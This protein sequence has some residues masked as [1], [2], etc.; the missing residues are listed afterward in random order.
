MASL[1]ELQDNFSRAILECNGELITEDVLPDGLTAEERYWIYRNNSYLTLGLA[2]ARNFPVLCQLVGQRFFDH[3]AEEYV[4]KYPP[5]NALMMSY[6]A[7]MADFLGEFNPVADLPYLADVARLEHLWTLCFNG[8]DCF[9]EENAG[10]FDL[11]QLSKI[12]PERFND[13]ILNFL[14][15]MQLMSSV[16]PIVDIWRANQEGCRG[17][18]INIDCGGCYLLLFRRAQAVEIMALDQANYDFLD[19]IRQGNALGRAAEEIIEKY[20][21]FDLQAALQNIL[22]N[23]LI[24]SISEAETE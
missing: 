10:G 24:E 14:P 9:N 22:H 19:R 4:K 3:M 13:L 12:A 7:S 11:R 6:G 16:Y 17:E 5:E 21:E 2:L 1:H 15:N 23:E 20:P 18:T 8:P